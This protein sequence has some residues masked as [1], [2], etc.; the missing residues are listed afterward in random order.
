MSPLLAEGEAIRAPTANEHP[1]QRFW[2]PDF[3][4]DR[5]GEA[6]YSWMCDN[7]RVMDL[8]E[9]F[10]LQATAAGGRFGVKM[11]TE[12]IRWELHVSTERGDDKYKINNNHSAY[13][14]RWLVHRHPGVRAALEIRTSPGS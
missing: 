14:A 7:P 5:L 1:R 4:Q 9:H 10:A 3:Y 11:V 13:I 8:Y 2:V 12:R 6:A